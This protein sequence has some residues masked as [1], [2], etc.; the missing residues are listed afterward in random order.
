MS[1]IPWKEGVA[2]AVGFVVGAL[3]G[4]GLGQ[5]LGA[6][7][8]APGYETSTIIGI[9]LTGFGGGAGLQLARFWRSRQTGS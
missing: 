5:L 2:D 9:A 8:F 6:D 1:D 3:C 4:F 7:V